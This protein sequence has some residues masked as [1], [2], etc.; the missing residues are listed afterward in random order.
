MSCQNC[1]SEQV[2]CD[3]R[4]RTKLEYMGCDI[5][6]VTAVY[7]EVDG[8]PCVMELIQQLDSETLI[9][10]ENGNRLTDSIAG[11]HAKLYHDALTGGYNRRYF[12]DVAKS[13]TEPAGVAVL[14]LDD[15]KLYNDTYGHHAGDVALQTAVDVVRSC[16]RKSDTLIRYG[17]DEFLL[18]TARLSSRPSPAPTS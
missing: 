13:K 6:Q 5:F 8:Q 7:R 12:E 18:V 3:H 11:Y 16:I 17:G 14:D 9:D 15:F 10:P 1:I 2:L 4:Q